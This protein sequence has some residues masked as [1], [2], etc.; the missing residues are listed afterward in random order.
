MS[1]QGSVSRFIAENYDKVEKKS[2][3]IRKID[4]KPENKVSIPQFP[5]RRKISCE[6]GDFETPKSSNHD[7]NSRPSRTYIIQRTSYKP[8]LRRAS[9]RMKMKTIY[10]NLS[11]IGSKINENNSTT[12]R[13]I[14]EHEEPWKAV[15]IIASLIIFTLI[16]LFIIEGH[17]VTKFLMPSYPFDHKKGILNEFLSMLKK[18][19]SKFL[20]K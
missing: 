11:K 10:D 14:D 19:F 15:V 20:T 3:F 13:K 4:K 2:N 1:C 12:G 6:M 8:N 16:S 5:F 7:L 9:E 18:I 17:S